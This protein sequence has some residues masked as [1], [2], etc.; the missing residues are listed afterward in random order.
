MALQTKTPVSGKQKIFLFQDQDAV[1]GSDATFPGFQT[2]G[3]WTIEGDLADEQTKNGRVLG[4]AQHEE[5]GEVDLFLAED[6]GGQQLLEDARKNQKVLKCWNVTLIK[7]AQGK[8]PARFAYILIESYEEGQASDGFVEVTVSFQVIG[9]SQ[10]G[11]LDLADAFVEM[12][13]YAFETP[14]ETGTPAP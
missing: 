14:G 4:Y 11:E 7:N 6:D 5:S 8:Y 13:Q 2:D 3:T 1:V 10:D 9:K 12:A